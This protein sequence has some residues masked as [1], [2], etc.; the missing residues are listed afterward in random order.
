MQWEAFVL[1]ML[2]LIIVSGYTSINAIVK[3]ELFPVQIRALGVGFPYAVTVAIF[4]GTAEAVALWLKKTGHEPLF[5]WYVTAC[6]FISLCVF[7]LMQDTKKS[8]LI[9]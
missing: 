9:R 6:I 3:A 2:A 8:S 5:Y 7:V 4:G 1:I